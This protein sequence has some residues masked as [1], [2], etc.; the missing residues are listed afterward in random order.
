MFLSS[1]QPESKGVPLSPP[2][3]GLGFCGAWGPSSTPLSS[4][5]SC[6]W[7][8]MDMQG[9]VAQ[10]PGSY[11]SW[12]YVD[13]KEAPRAPQ[14]HCPGSLGTEGQMA[15]VIRFLDGP[16]VMATSLPAFGDLE[17]DI[18]CMCNHVP[19]PV[20]VKNL[21]LGEC[22]PPGFCNSIETHY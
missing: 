1:L 17:A 13:C 5:V 11:Q 9:V 8:L 12:G 16:S 21:N 4:G 19:S 14:S 10:L 3:V 15:C 7:H 6:L 18:S 2:P 20:F 22:C